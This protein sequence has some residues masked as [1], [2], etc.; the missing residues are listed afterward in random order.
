[1]SK[2]EPNILGLDVGARQIGASVFR[3]GEL[4]FYKVKSIKKTSGAETLHRLELVLAVLIEKYRI[5]AVALKKPVYPQQH[6]SFVKPVYETAKAFIVKNNL[7]L[8]E[9]DPDMIYKIICRSAKPTKAVTAS[10]LSERYAELARYF[11]VPKLWQKRYYAQLFD[12]IAAGLV[13]ARELGRN[14]NALGIIFK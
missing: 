1:M 7:R 5:E 3:G 11:N 12:A 2:I 6:R 13:C 9:Y 10:L 8:F 4:V 14:R